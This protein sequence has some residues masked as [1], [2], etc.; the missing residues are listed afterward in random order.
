MVCFREIFIFQAFFVETILLSNGWSRPV[1]TKQIHLGHPSQRAHRGLNELISKVYYLCMAMYANIYNKVLSNKCAFFPVRLII[2]ISSSFTA[3][4]W[5]IQL[6]S[7]GS[8]RFVTTLYYYFGF[9]MVLATR[10]IPWK[11][12]IF[13]NCSIFQITPKMKMNSH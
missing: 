6:C 8:C 10:A 11:Y 12:I 5:L 13:T 1:V 2:S 7:S 3:C 4:T 9:C